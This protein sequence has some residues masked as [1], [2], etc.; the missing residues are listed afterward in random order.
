M[1]GY[2][3]SL[4]QAPRLC[5]KKLD[6]ERTW[7]KIAKFSRDLFS[8]SAPHYF[9]AWNR[10]LHWGHIMGRAGDEGS[11]CTGYSIRPK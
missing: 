5:R 1:S 9:G 7:K 11:L 4:F 2:I 8:T 6:V 3:S 10:L